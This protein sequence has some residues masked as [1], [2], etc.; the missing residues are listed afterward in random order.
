MKRCLKCGR[1]YADETL[2]FC[3]ADGSLLSAPY[4]PDIKLS[5]SSQ[6]TSSMTGIRQSRSPRV[7]LVLLIVSAVVLTAFVVG[8][9]T[10][11]WLE[12]RAR[13]SATNSSSAS[14]KN[15]TD[16]LPSLPGATTTPVVVS[17]DPTATPRVTTSAPPASISIGGRW[18][19]QFGTITSVSQNGNVFQLTGVGVACRGNFQSSGSGTIEGNSVELNY[20]SSYSRGRCHGTISADGSRLTSRCSDTVC[21]GFQSV[22]HRLN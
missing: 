14:N 13:T 10:I 18:R 8:G 7:G 19:D 20:Q 2:A 3:L 15:H 21:G 11:A 1:T 6:P 22:A 9:S 4:E 12:Y 5:P 16:E 17:P